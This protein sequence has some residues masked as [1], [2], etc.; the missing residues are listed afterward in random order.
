[1]NKFCFIDL[2]TSGLDEKKDKLL[3][4]TCIITD[5]KLNRIE[6]FSAVIKQ[7]IKALSMDE[8]CLKTHTDSNLLE[9][10]TKSTTTLEEVEDKMIRLLR[11]HFPVSRPAMCGS[12]V[13]FDARFI[14]EHLPKVSSKFHYRIIDVSSF[15]LGISMYHDIILPKGRE[16]TVHRT[17]PDVLDS[18]Q[19]LKTY[20]ERFR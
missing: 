13:H 8:W 20:L 10:C 12:S 19:Y 11:K 15:M 7:D 16:V 9:E 3:E 14:K 4:I 18:I 1:M 6:D 17:F 2:E 5:N